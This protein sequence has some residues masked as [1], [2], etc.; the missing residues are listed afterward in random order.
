LGK[1]D[2]DSQIAELLAKR[3][4][5]SRDEFL[6]LMVPDVSQEASEF[7]W[8]VS[9]DAIGFLKPELTI[10]PDDNLLDDLPIDQGEWDLD[11]PSEWADRQGIPETGLP[12]W[13]ED[14]P[15]TIRN[16]GLWLDLGAAQGN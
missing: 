8:E 3:V 9:V 14:C 1:R 10:H 13:P 15:V 6:A 4:N 12:D 7:L 11:W 16:F 2:T 5:P